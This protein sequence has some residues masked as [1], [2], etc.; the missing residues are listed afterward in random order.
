MG[1]TEI[2]LIVGI[3]T[4]EIIEYLSNFSPADSEAVM[5]SS[6]VSYPG[7]FLRWIFEIEGRR[8]TEYLFEYLKAPKRF[9]R[10]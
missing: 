4:L 1:R 5:K 10:D 9:H 8:L 7:R 6:K 2:G 3:P